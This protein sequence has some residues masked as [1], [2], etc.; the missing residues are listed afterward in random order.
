MNNWE[1]DLARMRTEDK[2]SNKFPPMN[3]M[4]RHSNFMSGSTVGDV[5]KGEMF[6]KENALY[7][8]DKSR[9]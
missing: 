8:R 7:A 9:V 4:T 3:L 2:I 6:E 1:E 5:I